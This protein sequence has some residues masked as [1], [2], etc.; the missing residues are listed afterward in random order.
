MSKKIPQVWLDWILENISLGVDLDDIYYTLVQNGFKKKEI[1]SV[2]NNYK[3][4]KKLDDS[5]LDKDK[6]IK[7]NVEEFK[8]KFKEIPSYTEVGFS[9][10]KL[11]KE[12]H[13]KIN[14]FY[15]ANLANKK[16]E[17]VAGGYIQNVKEDK[18]SSITIELPDELRDEIHSSIQD[19]IE[20][21]SGMELLPTYVYGVRMYL[22]G[23][24]LN[25]HKDREETHIIGTIIN[26]DQKVRNDWYLEIEDHQKNL[27]KVLLEPGEM[28]FYESATLKHGRPEPLSG[29]YYSNIFC[30]YMPK[31]VS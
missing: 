26:I 22:D 29:E 6:L 13:A 23:A 25:S 20:E 5:L 7:K 11:P 8:N 27:H 12:I 24:I 4:K 3:P 30:H 10:Q 28:I 2:L 17:N 1:N 31:M 9:K 14:K 18:E 19:L 21:W 16:E 15:K